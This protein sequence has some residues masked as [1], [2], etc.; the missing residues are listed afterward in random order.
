MG[1]FKYNPFTGKLDYVGN[2]GSGPTTDLH[3]ATYIVNPTPDAG[4][5]YTTIQDAIDAVVNDGFAFGGD[6]FIFPGTYV[7]TLTLPAG[8]LNFVGWTTS[9]N[10]TLPSLLGDMTISNGSTVSFNNVNLQ[11]SAIGVV[12]VTTDII[13]DFIFNRCY[14]ADS[15][16]LGVVNCTAGAVSA[17]FNDCTLVAAGGPLCNLVSAFAAP[18]TIIINRCNQVGNT[19]PSN[20]AESNLVLIQNS[21]IQNKFELSDSCLFNAEYTTFG[22]ADTDFITAKNS[23]LSTLKYCTFNSRTQPAITIDTGST[24]RLLFCAIDSTAADAVTGTGTL[25]YSPIY[26][27]GSCV[28]TDVST[29]T[30]IPVKT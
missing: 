10:Q 30:P 27:L 20:I 26:F 17:V 13:A 8:A 15:S 16:S 22:P 9:T 23:L 11:S 18:S 1:N 14:I 6:I 4:G 28:T 2:G 19:V 21:L 29:E 5:N 3:E 24:V 25:L 12:N 7:E